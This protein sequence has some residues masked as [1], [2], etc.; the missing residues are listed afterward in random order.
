MNCTGSYGRSC[1]RL[2]ELNEEAM[3]QCEFCRLEVLVASKL[4]TLEETWR[5][6]DLLSQHFGETAIAKATE[7]RE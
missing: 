6:N 2:L 4:A 3:G 1:G 5:Y 7:G